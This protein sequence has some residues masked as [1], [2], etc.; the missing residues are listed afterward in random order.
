MS[1]AI[2]YHYFNSPVGRLRLLLEGDHKLAIIGL[3]FEREQEEISPDWLFLE[4]HH[5][6]QETKQALMAYFKGG[7]NTFTALPLKLIGTEFQQQVWR[8]LQ[9]IP[10]GQ[11]TTYGEIAQRIGRV[12][13]VRAVGGA[14]GRNPISIII[15]CH[16]VL[17][18]G[19]TLTG[20]GGGLPIKRQLLQHEQIE[21]LDRGIEFVKPKRLHHLIR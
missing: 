7:K 12:K 19:Q 2:Y 5:L 14:I 1:Q 15:P 6:I 13:A 4:E 21:Y 9:Q 20:F 8:A 16:R 3:D 11:S 17:G 10:F 18:I